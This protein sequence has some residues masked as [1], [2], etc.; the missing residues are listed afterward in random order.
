MI[1]RI[2]IGAPLGST[3]RAA[4]AFAVL[5][6]ILWSV[7]LGAAD[8]PD[9]AREE[10]RLAERVKKLNRSA[11][12]YT[13]FPAD[14]R[15]RSFKFHES[16]V[17]RFSN[18]TLGTKDGAMYL[19]V[20]R[21]R[22]RA[23]LKLY[24]YDDEH[25]S[26]EWQSLSEGAIA[27]E[28]DGK[29]VWNPTDPG[30]RFSELPD[31]PGPAETAAERLRQ[32]KALAEKFSATY[33][34]GPPGTKP[35]ELRLLI[36][37]LFRY[38]TGDDPNCL[39]GAVFAFANGTAP[40]ALLLLEARRGGERHKWHHA[41]ARMASGAV[42]ARYAEKEVFSVARYDFSKDPKQTFLWL[43]RQPVPKD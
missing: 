26:H 21:G 19:W 25:F 24:T 12:Q 29:P 2:R 40:P 36:R 23:M 39:D 18:P 41:F 3:R 16:A 13:V 15:K 42:S 34:D 5:V 7:P 28:R 33:T 9:K 32:M 10:A 37:P 22:P 8:E 43:P 31:A 1:G 20:D 14:D 6:G 38:E 4:L 27:A 11:A 30:L 17:L 35:V